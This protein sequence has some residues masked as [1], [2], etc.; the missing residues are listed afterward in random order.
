MIEED[1][2]MTKEVKKLGVV[3]Q[4]RPQFDI[5]PQPKPYCIFETHFY[6]GLLLY[7]YTTLNAVLQ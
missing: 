1:C 7:V 5:W 4:H 3:L 6:A 2:G